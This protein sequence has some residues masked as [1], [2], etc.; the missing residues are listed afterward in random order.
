MESINEKLF[1]IDDK[2]TETI[3]SKEARFDFLTVSKREEV[4]I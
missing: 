3:T 4:G 2:V 1:K